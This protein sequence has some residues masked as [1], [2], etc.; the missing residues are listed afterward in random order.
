MLR[1]LPADTGQTGVEDRS[2]RF[3]LD[4]PETLFGSP[5]PQ[6][7]VSGSPE[8]HSPDHPDQNLTI[9]H[10]RLGTGQTG[11]GHQLD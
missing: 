3:T 11:T 6:Q 1:V 10:E 7:K 8:T 5:E 2:N 4:L 9:F